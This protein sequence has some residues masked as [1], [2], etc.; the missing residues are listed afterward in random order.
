MR[1]EGHRILTIDIGPLDEAAA[2]LYEGPWIAERYAVAGSAIESADP[3]LDASVVKVIEKAKGFNAVQAFEGLYA[4]KSAHARAS[5]IWGSVD[6]IMLPTAP[7][8]PTR[9]E[10][11]ADPVGANA[12]LGRYTNSV[13][14]LGWS[15]IA[16]PAG[17]TPG[18]LPWGVSFIAPGGCDAALLSWARAWER[19][20]PGPL[21][22]H[23]GPR[24]TDFVAD[25]SSR[26]SAASP[27][28]ELPARI[29]GEPLL[30]I[31]VVG[32][33]LEGM[34]LH[35][36]V[37]A[38]GAR[39]LARTRTASC[40]RLF[41]LVGGPP[42]RPGLLRV[43]AGAGGLG[44]SVKAIAGS[45]AG[46]GGFSAV[47]SGS[48]L[49]PQPDARGAIMDACSQSGASIEVEVYAFPVHA[50]GAFLAEIAPPLGLGRI[51]LEDGRWVQ[52]FICEPWGI[53]DA[54][55][56]TASGGW[57]YHLGVGVSPRNPSQVAASYPPAATGP[58]VR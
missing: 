26:A 19:M 18:G 47:P 24:D 4:L 43:G 27:S 40:Y 16:L 11:A 12:R 3:G 35:H 1:R 17:F 31:A 36:Q 10:V 7:R 41:A 55:D 54:E 29:A 33:H 5:R 57:R 2:L 6:V 46:A 39:L 22:A 9:A 34:P 21:G 32:A 58:T 13:N 37:I 8:L 28:F 51:E 30:P 44:R 45:G 20:V 25:D 38:A 50:V 23:L 49:G 52:G 15:A 48:Q 56:I 42:H 53:L 14:L